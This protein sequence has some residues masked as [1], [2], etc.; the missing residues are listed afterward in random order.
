MVLFTSDL[1][2]VSTQRLNRFDW[3]VAGSRLVYTVATSGERAN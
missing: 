1:L 2:D 3:F